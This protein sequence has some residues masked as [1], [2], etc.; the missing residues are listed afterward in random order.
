MA[1][2]GR[3]DATAA[4]LGSDTARMEGPELRRLVEVHFPAHRSLS[5][6]LLIN[7]LQAYVGLCDLLHASISFR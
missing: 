6:R 4:A 2:V 1:E 7:S 5:I 3:R